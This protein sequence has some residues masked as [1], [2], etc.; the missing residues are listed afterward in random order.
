[1]RTIGAE[2]LGNRTAYAAGSPGDERVR[3]FDLQWS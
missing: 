2:R 3:P 1:M